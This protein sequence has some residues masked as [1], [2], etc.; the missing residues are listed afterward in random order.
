[1]G[2]S[3]ELPFEV[4]LI[5]GANVFALVFDSFRVNLKDHSAMVSKAWLNFGLSF[6][7]HDIFQLPLGS[8]GTSVCISP[9]LARA[10][11][12]SAC[13]HFPWKDTSAATCCKAP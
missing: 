6:F 13:S 10:K 2:L 9:S 12:V 3:L 4:A 5:S 7:R 1:M 8:L 11:M